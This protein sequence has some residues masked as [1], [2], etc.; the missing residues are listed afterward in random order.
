MKKKIKEKKT[1][2]DNF[3]SATDVLWPH[4]FIRKAGIFRRPDWIHNPVIK[5]LY[6]KVD[7]TYGSSEAIRDFNPNF[8]EPKKHLSLFFHATSV[9]VGYFTLHVQIVCWWCSPLLFVH[10]LG[11]VAVLFFFCFLVRS[12]QQRPSLKERSF[13]SIPIALQDNLF[14]TQT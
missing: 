8:N 14:L 4:V 7:K 3:A 1:R 12:F 5:R 6:K 9:M 11:S 10:D 13:P 2:K